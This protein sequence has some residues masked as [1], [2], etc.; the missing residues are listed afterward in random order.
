M[1]SSRQVLLRNEKNISNLEMIVEL[2]TGKKK[3]FE[4][5]VRHL[6]IKILQFLK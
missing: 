6:L 5:I 3:I 1:D 2:L 4:S